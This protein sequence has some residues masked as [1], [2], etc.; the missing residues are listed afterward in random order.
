MAA[1]DVLKLK[2][3]V[4]PM[5]VLYEPTDARCLWTGKMPPYLPGCCRGWSCHLPSDFFLNAWLMQLPMLAV[6][7]WLFTY[8]SNW[9][10]SYSQPPSS[11]ALHVART[12]HATTFN[13]SFFGILSFVDSMNI[14]ESAAQPT[15]LLISNMVCV[16]YH[17]SKSGT[18]GLLV[19]LV[20][21]TTSH[22]WSN[23]SSICRLRMWVSRYTWGCLCMLLLV[24]AEP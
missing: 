12:K 8:I 18:T 9:T 23:S 14:I 19:M 3:F 5:G 6:G 7:C 24:F 21:P 17:H 2:G 1:A 20:T 15:Y 22:S 16:F 10:S 4:C 11:P 13:S